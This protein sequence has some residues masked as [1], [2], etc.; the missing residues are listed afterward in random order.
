M[1]NA[2]SNKK[3]IVVLQ[4]TGGNDALNTV[5]PYNDG[6]YY[7]NRPYVN[8]AQ[9]D[10][11]RLDDKLGLNPSL[12]P[13]KSLWDRGKVAVI[14]GVGYPSPNR[15]H[16]RSMD[17]WH[18]AESEEVA[19]EGW[20]GKAVRDLDP[21][22][23]NVLTGV[24]FGRGLPRALYAQ[25]V[26][27][28]SVGNLATYG[29]FPDIQED[30]AR[31]LALEAFS[32]MYGGAGKDVIAKFISQTG[33]DALKGA[34]TLRV[35]PQRYSSSI[36]YAD[37]P[38]ADNMK[39]IAQVMTADLGTRIFYTQHGSF[40]THSSE[41]TTH[42]KLWGDVSG[43]V[44]DF[45][46]DLEEHGADK[47]TVILLFSEFGRRIKDNGAG[48]DHGSGGVAFVIGG[49]VKGGLYGDFPSLEEDMQ[50]EGDM[51]FTNDF[52]GTYSTILERWMGLDPVTIT[53]G[54]YE[55]FDFVAR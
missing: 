7:D 55:Q 4:L 48:T 1:A 45:M 23:E 2:D 51:H 40:D 49:D 17:V 26:P 41:L 18:T 36:E 21:K 46:D 29:L 5:I 14:C 30:A 15:S 8:I 32:Q 38:I 3:N 31:N 43:A 25:G 54:N 52:R 33:T 50:L 37:N 13:I 28:A 27:V 47:D 22:A 12:A 19:L 42:A 53:G 11:L 10:V 16:F 34:D 24:N 9:E 35:A 39:S 6:N 44:G 20:L